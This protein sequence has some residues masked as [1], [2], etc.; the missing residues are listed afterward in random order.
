MIDDDYKRDIISQLLLTIDGEECIKVHLTKGYYALVDLE[1]YIKVKDTIWQ[2]SKGANTHYATA[3]H[4]LKMHRIIMGLFYND[5]KE[6]DHIN[7]DGLD[8]RKANLRVC[9]RAENTLNCVRRRD[10]TSGYKGVCYKRGRWEAYIQH[11]HKWR[12]IGY[13]P[14]DVL[15]AQAY[16]REA[17]LLHGEFAK[18]N[19]VPL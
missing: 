18:L 10:N 15:A 9:T 8:N 16:N 13:Y 19:E 6:V 1:Y 4:G 17:T 3:A 12:H 7:G 5:S 2:V 11:N 14:T